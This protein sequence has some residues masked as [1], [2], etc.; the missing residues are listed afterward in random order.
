MMGLCFFSEFYGVNAGKL[1]MIQNIFWV[2]TIHISCAL[3]LF[4]DNSLAH[5]ETNDHGI[6]SCVSE[7]VW[8]KIKWMSKIFEIIWK[9]FKLKLKKKY[10][11]FKK[12]VKI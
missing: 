12:A 2:S 10:F 1:F 11:G 5:H 6:S 4:H 7:S 3:L 9:N 8:C